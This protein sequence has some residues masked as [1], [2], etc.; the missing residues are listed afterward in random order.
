MVTL[1]FLEAW[2]HVLQLC[3]LR[4]GEL[5]CV[6]VGDASHPDSVE[7]ARLSAQMM[8]ARLF[9][10]ELGE[11][12]AAKIAGESTATQGPTALSGNRGAVEALKHSDLVIDLMG[13]DRGRE[14]TE[15]LA[16]GTRILLVKEPPDVLMRLLPRPED[17]I[18]VRAAA[19]R[20]TRAK[21][22]HVT[23]KTGTH[24]TVGL[25]EF[26]VLVQYGYADEPGRWDHW[27]SAFA[28]GW[29]NEGTAKGRVILSPGDC[30]LPFKS[31]VR[32]PIALDI[33]GGYIRHIVGDL[34]ARYLRD[35]MDSFHDPEGY[36]V[37]H[38]GWGVHS[39][40]HWTMLGMYDKRQTNAMDARSFSG[41]FMFSTGPNA[42]AGGNRHTPCHLDIP[43]LDCSV[44][45]DGKPATIDG[46]VV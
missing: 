3:N 40:A 43:M 37:A 41:N 23:S 27:P 46:R 8:G 5:V 45:L 35:Y 20:L 31:Y 13:I 32:S 44:A 29:P 2:K 4:A 11:A 6:L 9:K 30:I 1:K 28:A 25:G 36:A 19:D 12:P 10:L 38:L 15:I 33:E 21:I 22:M 14:Q 18:A 24:L 39:R 42:E 26:P 16:T 34:D 17:R 7:A